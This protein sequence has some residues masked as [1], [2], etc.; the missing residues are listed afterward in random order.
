L[1][2]APVPA[3]FLWPGLISLRQKC[4]RKPAATHMSYLK[5]GF[6]AGFDHNACAESSQFRVQKVLCP[7]ATLNWK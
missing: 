5:A 2:K 1:Q 4:H 3:L 6:T 7:G